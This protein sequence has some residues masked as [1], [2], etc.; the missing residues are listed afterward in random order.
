[1]TKPKISR[2]PVAASNYAPGFFSEPVA[3]GF[4]PGFKSH[5]I[6]NVSARTKKFMTDHERS[7]QCR[8]SG[9]WNARPMELP[10]SLT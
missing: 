3:A 7:Q 1:M 6:F 8:T 4:P 5:P 2:K 9:G 10:G